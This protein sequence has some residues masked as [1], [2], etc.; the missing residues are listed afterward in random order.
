MITKK[1]E[2]DRQRHEIFIPTFDGFLS[3][4]KILSVQHPLDP[5]DKIKRTNS[6]YFQICISQVLYLYI[7]F[8][9]GYIQNF[10]PLMQISCPIFEQETK[11][12]LALYPL[13]LYC[14]AHFTF[15][16]QL[17]HSISLF[18]ST[19]Q[20]LF[21]WTDYHNEFDTHQLKISAKLLLF[22]V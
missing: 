14:I 4:Q 7:I 6:L 19:S 15:I 10:R 13:K 1:T 3:I 5:V 2:K 9:N 21:K 8:N 12:F 11:N 20:N 22:T 18:S 17:C 16:N